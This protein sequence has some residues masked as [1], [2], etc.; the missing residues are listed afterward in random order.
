ML[1]WEVNIYVGIWFLQ[2]LMCPSLYSRDENALLAVKKDPYYRGAINPATTK[3]LLLGKTSH[4]CQM[5][6]KSFRKYKPSLLGQHNSHNRLQE[7]IIFHS[8]ALQFPRNS[9]GMKFPH[10]CVGISFPRHY[11]GMKFPK[12]GVGMRFPQTICRNCILFII[13]HPADHMPHL[14][15]Q[16]SACG[17]S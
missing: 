3:N 1:Y 2:T 5:E 17:G 4:I 7:L 13:L 14:I 11:V 6:L 16:I 9:M 10:H 15:Y 8:H 12:N